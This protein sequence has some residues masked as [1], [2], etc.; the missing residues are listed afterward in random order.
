MNIIAEIET[1]VRQLGEE[2]VAKLLGVK[3]PVI[4][5]YI[6]GRVPHHDICQKVVDLWFVESRPYRYEEP[7]KVYEDR[8]ICLLMPTYKFIHPLCHYSI[9]AFWERSRMRYQQRYGDAEIKRSRNHLARRFLR[10]TKCEWSLWLDDDMIFPWGDALDF[11]QKT[12]LNMPAQFAS[13]LTPDR[14]VSWGK[15]IVSALYYDRHGQN[16]MTIGAKKAPSVRAPHNSLAPVLYAGMGCMLVHRKV[17]LDIAEKF[18]ETW[19][20]KAPGNECGMFTENMTA[21]G[22]MRGEDEAFG[23]RALQAGHETFVDMGLIPGHVGE[24]IYGVPE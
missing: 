3:R 15:T 21:E 16:T 11:N 12:H 17:Y 4:R 1:R 9:M 6:Q 18:P 7:V 8:S 20:E 5:G 19:N 24:K 23:W 22:R 13:L 10:D 2:Q 14:L